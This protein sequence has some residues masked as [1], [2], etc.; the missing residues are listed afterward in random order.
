MPHDKCR[1]DNGFNK[2]HTNDCCSSQDSDECCILVGPTGPRGRPGRHGCDGHCGPMGP[3]GPIGPTGSLGLTGPIGL[4]GPGPIVYFF[5]ENYTGPNVVQI[6]PNIELI[7][8]E[9][10]GGG[11]AG[12]DGFANTASSAGGGGGGSGYF[13]DMYFKPITGINQISFGVGKGGKISVD[14]NGGNTIF[15]YGRVDSV[16]TAIPYTVFGG[17]GGDNASQNPVYPGDGGAGRYGGG[18]G[19]GDNGK[20]GD[21]SDDYT[22]G[23]DGM[24]FSTR[25]FSRGS[26]GVGGGAGS[27][28][29]ITLETSPGYDH[30]KGFGGMSNIDGCGTGGGGGGYLGGNGGMFFTDSQF[31]YDNVQGDNAGSYG[32]GGGGGA[33]F[34]NPQFGNARNGL[35][36]NGMGGYIKI[37]F[38]SNKNTFYNTLTH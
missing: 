15:D 27:R 25:G 8:I 11:G 22:N 26:G 16:G 4:P 13:A 20:A 9:A 24:S 1:H 23:Q 2:R 14:K 17:V 37:T 38:Y 18:G 21:G 28:R 31:F 7:R 10:M 36:G 3:M 33:G 12:G 5:D 35:G 19:G 30:N 29:G 34:Y 6:P 32:S